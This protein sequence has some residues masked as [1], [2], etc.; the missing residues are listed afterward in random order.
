MG[1]QTAEALTEMD[2][3]LEAQLLTHLR[4]N[5]YPPVPSYMVAVAKQAIEI[6]NETQQGN[7]LIELPNGVTYRGSKS[8]SVFGVIEAFHLDPWCD[9]NDY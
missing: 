9:N 1:K 4:C 2:M 8:V 7:Q 3:G 5:H 6:Y